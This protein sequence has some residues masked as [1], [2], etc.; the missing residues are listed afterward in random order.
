[1]VWG[2]LGFAKLV[3]K[4]LRIRLIFKPFDGGK[5]SLVGRLVTKDCG[6]VS[7][8]N[9]GGFKDAVA[10]G[11]VR[12]A[13]KLRRTQRKGKRFVR[14]FCVGEEGRLGRG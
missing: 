13:F 1:M 3:A 4:L 11:V 12:H 2:R 14:L 10:D 6:L 9:E 8:R 5:S 7:E